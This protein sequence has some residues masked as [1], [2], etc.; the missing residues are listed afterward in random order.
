MLWFPDRMGVEEMRRTIF[1]TLPAFMLLAIAVAW[2]AP[3]LAGQAGAGATA[4]GQPS[5]K[6]GEWPM[7][8]ADLRGGNSPSARSVS[9]PSKLEVAWR[10]KTDNLGTRGS[11]SKPRRSW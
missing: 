5:T 6:N 1:R 11:S 3:R 4:T 2:T 8:T 10:F 9:N 7:Y